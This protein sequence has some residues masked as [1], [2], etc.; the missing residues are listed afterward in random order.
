MGSR[1]EYFVYGVT[2]SGDPVCC[3][4]IGMA[5]EVVALGAASDRPSSIRKIPGWTRYRPAPSYDFMPG[6]NW[7]SQWTDKRK[8]G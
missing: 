8:G 3:P 5:F 2:V 7:T 4:S 6:L 1:Q